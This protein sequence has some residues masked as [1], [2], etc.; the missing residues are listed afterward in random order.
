ME[1]AQDL[2]EETE[3]LL[4]LIPADCVGGTAVKALRA[5]DRLDRTTPAAKDAEQAFEV[6]RGSLFASAG[7]LLPHAPLDLAA[8]G[9]EHL[10]AELATKACCRG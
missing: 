3:D 2:L 9:R 6:A 1:R 4:A 8:F 10:S 7:Q 5:I